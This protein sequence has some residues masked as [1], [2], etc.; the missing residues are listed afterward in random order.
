MITLRSL[1]QV[2]AT[3]ANHRIDPGL[4]LITRIHTGYFAGLFQT[5]HHRAVIFGS[6]S[7]ALCL[8][9]AL[10]DALTDLCTC[11]ETIRLHKTFAP[12]RPA[13]AF[14]ARHRATS[15]I[16]SP[17]VGSV[18]TDIGAGAIA[19]RTTGT[20]ERDLCIADGL[21]PAL[22]EETSPQREGELSVFK[23]DRSGLLDLGPRQRDRV[24]TN[25]ASG[26]KGSV[27]DRLILAQEAA[28]DDILDT[29]WIGQ[30][31]RE[32]N[33]FPLRNLAD[34]RVE[35]EENRPS[36]RHRR[37]TGRYQAR[38]PPRGSG[39]CVARAWERRGRRGCRDGHA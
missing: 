30:E 7:T 36:V 26:D 17:A 2:A 31:S 6:K 16:A 39:G 8:F 11:R 1:V 22:I 18:S 27:V 5:L 19:S 37:A 28:P 32:D 23:V 10:T 4:D 25:L 20:C 35:A 3:A 14:T 29:I 33:G 15:V 13:L 21:I 12:N 38:F 9:A 34:I 24:R